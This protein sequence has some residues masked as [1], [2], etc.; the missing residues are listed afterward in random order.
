MQLVNDDLKP[1]AMD[2]RTWDR[3][4]IA[5]LWV[6]M[7]VCIPTYMLAA[8]MISAGMRWWQALFT[9]FLGNVIVLIPMIL[10]A[11]AGTK[12]G[13]P[14]PILARASFGVLGS[15]VPALLRAIVACGWFGI[16]TWIGGTAIL[17]SVAVFWPGVNHLPQ[18]L[19]DFFGVGTGAFICFLIFWAINLWIIWR[20][21]ETIKWLEAWAAPFLIAAGLA[22]LGWAIVKVGSVSAIL[23][24]GVETAEAG[25]FAKVFVPMLTAM[26]GFWATLSLNIADFSRYAK[27]QREQQIGQAIGLPPTMALF[28]FIGIAVT[29]ATVILYGEALWDP[30][31]VVSR[32]ESP[33]VLFVSMFALMIATL[34]TN[35]AANVVGPANDFSNLYPKKIGFKRGGLI[36]GVIGLLIMPWKLVA[37]PSGYIFTWLIGYS[38]LLGPIAGIILVDYYVIRKCELNAEDLYLENGEYRYWNGFNVVALVALLGGVVPNLPGFLVQIG[39]LAA[40]TV[41]GIWTSLYQYAWFVGL[42]VAGVLYFAMMSLMSGVRRETADLKKI[43]TDMV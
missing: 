20:G 25:A 17:A 9:V 7:C 28:S 41:S 23:N 30:V 37:D 1:V 27:N 18:V 31:Q 15:N 14:F 43:L 40:D 29:G 12:Y 34:S 16:Q 11:H 39:I 3:W 4:H 5:A 36:T 33:V 26:V 38:A 8:S 10:N 32:F 2:A 22:L 19:P 6:G 24:F 21:I 42:G 35:V 13:I